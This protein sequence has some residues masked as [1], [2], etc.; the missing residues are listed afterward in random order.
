[1]EHAVITWIAVA[2][3]GMIGTLARHAVN[4]AF[5]RSMR[6]APYATAS[7]NLIGSLLIGALAGSIAGGRLVLPASMRAFVFVGLLGG[8]TTFSSFMLDTLALAE[9]GAT[10]AALLNVA[11]QTVLGLGVTVAAYRLFA[12]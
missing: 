3:G 8:F 11:G 10:G 7:V 5:A 9:G 6:P 2:L 1:V 4:V 12:S